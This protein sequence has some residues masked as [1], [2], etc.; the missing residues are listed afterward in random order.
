MALHGRFITVVHIRPLELE[1]LHYWRSD[2]HMMHST[3]IGG[4]ALVKIIMNN[5]GN[6]SLP[7]CY[8]PS[9]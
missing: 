6:V 5:L 2:S 7:V 9:L 8:Q 1:P 3:F 4:H